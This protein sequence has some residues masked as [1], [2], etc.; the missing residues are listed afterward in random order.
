[1][2]VGIVG[3]GIAGLVTAWLLDR[4]C[5]ATVLEA[6]SRVGGNA[7]SATGC[8]DGV[9]GVFD[10]GTQE[11]AADESS[12]HTALLTAV[13]LDE[14]HLA[15][16][17]SSHTFSAAGHAFPLLVGNHP[18][19]PVHVGRGPAWET[20]RS[21]LEGVGE[22][23][24]WHVPFG[25]VVEPFSLP[26]EVRD[27]VLY[28]LPASLFGCPVADVPALS[29]RVVL[30]D[31]LG[32]ADDTVPR[33]RI[34]R[35]GMESLAWALAAQLT[36]AEIRTGAEV[37][38]VERTDDGYLLIDTTGRRCAV[39]QL[40][41]A[42]PAPTALR[43]LPPSMTGPGTPLHVLRRFT[44]RPLR[45][46]LH[47]DPA[48]VPH[49]RSLWSTQN[50]VSHDGWAE[51]SYWYGPSYGVDVFKSQ[52]TH[53][54]APPRRVLATS[55]FQALSPTT[56]AIGARQA[57]AAL[58]GHDGLHFAG[59]YTTGPGDQE[60]AIASGVDVARRIAPDSTRLRLLPTP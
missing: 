22:P 20:V 10:L 36:T 11:V 9:A 30:T 29:A 56:D 57:L 46:A 34:L 54:S 47:L 23:P 24:D 43:L 45:Y 12:L 28:A 7:R 39:E 49:D 3:A 6:R 14:R 58:Q 35:S 32:V 18:D 48:Y 55:T 37:D 21:F 19:R 17:P 50:L 16:V 5:T 15:D 38:R 59:H 2:R 53:R 31:L 33:A 25:A 1:M 40:V 42:V 41:L 44:Y 60:S 13:G 8:V 27:H 52:I 51:A 4:T 26:P